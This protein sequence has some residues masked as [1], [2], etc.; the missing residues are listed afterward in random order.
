[1][2]QDQ[3]SGLEVEHRGEWLDVEPLFGSF[4]VNIG[5]LLE[6][7]SDDLQ[8]TNHR[9]RAP[10]PGTERFCGLLYGGTTGCHGAGTGFT[11]RDEGE[12]KRRIDR[13]K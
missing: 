5:E 4:V 8:A 9:V 2:L 6:L 7:A 1:M 11:G 3:Q 13:P 10:K 12:I